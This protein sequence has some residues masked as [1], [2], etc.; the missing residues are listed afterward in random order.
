MGWFVAAI[1]ALGV[2]SGFAIWALRQNRRPAFDSKGRLTGWGIAHG[3]GWA[4]ELASIVVFALTL[5]VLATFEP[6]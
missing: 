2:L 6:S 1:V 4:V 5:I 3:A